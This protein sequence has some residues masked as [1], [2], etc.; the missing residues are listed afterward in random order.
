MNHSENYVD[1]K[2]GAH[3]QNIENFRKCAKMR[4]KREHGTARHMLDSYLC[5]FLWRDRHKNE[6]LFEKMLQ[7]KSAFYTL[8]KKNS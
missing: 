8:G 6:N 4:N 2:T 7:H 3:T 5:D 1:P